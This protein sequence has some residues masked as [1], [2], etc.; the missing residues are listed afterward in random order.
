MSPH[1]YRAGVPVN[2]QPFPDGSNVVKI[3]WKPKGARRLLAVRIP[4]T[5]QDVFLIE[6]GLK[7][8]GR[9]R[10]GICPVSL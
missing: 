4:D 10:M 2:C 8:F 3:E 6:K 9:E 1:K 5:L 7:R